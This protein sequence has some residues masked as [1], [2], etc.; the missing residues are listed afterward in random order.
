MNDYGV[1]LARPSSRLAFRQCVCVVVGKMSTKSDQVQT[2]ESNAYVE[3]GAIRAQRTVRRV[4]KAHEQRPWT[5]SNSQSPSCA[6]WLK[7]AIAT[8][9][10]NWASCN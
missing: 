10:M 8:R 4:T 3:C 5:T 9:S 2:T 7:P 1:D 6:G